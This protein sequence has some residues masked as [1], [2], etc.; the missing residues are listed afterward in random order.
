GVI[1]V[2]AIGGVALEHVVA[3]VIAVLEQGP[4]LT[5][6]YAS[7]RPGRGAEAIVDGRR[8]RLESDLV[9]TAVD[10][11]VRLADLLAHR[12]QSQAAG[13]VEIDEIVGGGEALSA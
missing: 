9:G 6:L 8:A 4:R 1:V 7:D 11:P 10:H 13:L 5:I 12:V 2:S 3:G